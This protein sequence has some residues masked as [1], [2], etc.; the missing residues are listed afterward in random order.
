MASWGAADEVIIK[1]QL[2]NNEHN[3]DDNNKDEIVK[4]KTN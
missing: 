4:Y 1:Q 3:C 2:Q